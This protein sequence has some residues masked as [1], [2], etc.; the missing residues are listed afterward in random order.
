MEGGWAIERKVIT[1]LFCDVVGSTELAER[2]DPEDVD[3]MM[4]TYHALARRRIE[5]HG[6]SVE[7][8]I[9]DAVVGVFGAP[10]VREDDAAR[11]VRAALTII[12]DL[13]ASGLGLE[14]RIGIHTGEAV[15]RVG[16]DR[17][18]EEGF[19]TGD[20]LNTAARLQAIANPGEIVAGDP[21]YRMAAR[22][23]EWEDLGPVALK[24]KSLP[25]QVW[26]PVR[27]RVEAAPS[28][29]EATPFLGR[30]AE[31]SVLL[32]AFE[33]AVR[34]PKVEL[35][36]IVA[37]AGMGKSRLIRELGRR[38]LARGGVT[39]RKGR[40]LPYGDGI[41][42]W[43]LG[44][45]VK[46]EAGV[47]ETDDQQTL[48]TKLDSAIR[49]PDLAVHAWFR[50]RLAPLVGLRT[51]ALA[52]TQEEAFSAWTRFLVSLAADGP[53]VLVF[54]DVHWADPA[55][56]AF[57]LQLAD[58]TTP[59]PILLVVTARPELAD[60][61][62]AWLERASSGTVQLASLADDAIRA[63]VEGTLEGGS[64]TLI[65]T[66]L[67]RAAGS[68][69]YAEQLAALIRERG[70]SATD[71]T[72]DASAIPS[73]V[74]ALL[75]ARIDALP[76]ELKPAL[77][78]A[79]VIGR[80]FWSGAIDALEAQEPGVV[81]PN[82]DALARRE[83]TRSVDPSSMLGEAEYAFWH[84]LL[85]DVAYSFLPR[86]AR[87]AKHRTA[88]AWITQ[89]AGSGLA[90]LAE[91]VAD[92]LRRALDLA[93][94][95]GAEDEV[96]SI[97]SDLASALMAAADHTARMDP[98]RAI[99]QF[100]QALEL[101]GQADL[102]R[103]A[104]LVAL[105]RALSARV[106]P[107]DAAS[108]L[109]EA[110]EAYR[111]AGDELAAAETSVEFARVL[112]N[113][114]RGAQAEAVIDAIRP[115]LEAHPG[116]GLVDLYQDDAVNAAAHN[117]V[118]RVIEFASRSLTLAASL[119]LPTPYRALAL[120]GQTREHLGD[121]RGIDEFHE[122]TELAVSAGDT[123]FALVAMAN[124]AGTLDHA[125]KALEAFDE[126]TALAARFGLVDRTTRALRLDT[127]ALAGRWDEVIE[128][129]P[130]LL[131]DAAFGGDAYSTFMARMTLA[132]VKLGRG[133]V[134]DPL[135]DLMDAA[136][137]IGFARYVPAG[138]VAVIAV[139]RGEHER[140][141]QILVEAVGLVGDGERLSNL[142][143]N[144]DA[145]IR[146][147]DL[148]LAQQLLAK[149]GRELEPSEGHQ[150]NRLA[151]AT[152]LEAEGNAAGA[153]AKYQVSAAWF[154]EFGW[155]QMQARALAGLGRCRIKLGDS[156]GGVQ[157]LRQARDIASYLRSP[158]LLASIDR[159]I[160]Q[161]R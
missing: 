116:S 141:R 104:A 58:L 140:A 91:I 108:A 151:R 128:E 118:G 28:T 17:Q 135:D 21:T 102:R 119:G 89:R 3:R 31:L 99:D 7:K 13:E 150:G 138:L 101:L 45:I 49:E 156:A 92:H 133:E 29:D 41:S 35:V 33:D 67:E 40:S 68:P 9:G 75:A 121:P 44:E 18:P 154:S 106:R 147:G 131:A 98:E 129:S 158:P 160:S 78:D 64:P 30:D 57:L 124:R 25:V 100:R 143:D 87:L 71:E 137:A 74:Q 96:P 123:R 14:M 84:A 115:Y 56:V 157:A 19:A 70:I 126:A 80:V 43:A 149:G 1:A 8:F 142:N 42:F 6:G 63:L 139:E 12:G 144:I 110:V 39:W 52:A 159:A 51:D 65:E 69:L 117:D 94:T 107:A 95:L 53:F 79:S 54:E 82:L 23:F 4:R 86:A 148:G 113:A 15:V 36:T 134:N 61:H 81:A 20:I 55:M 2:L 130:A 38:V 136:A 10:T 88:A 161:G 62:P 34:A 145:A 120:R 153:A 155:L 26:R 37:E 46:T 77:L 72:L 90:D 132:D 59:V 27:P 111:A 22:E 66:V 114:G 109:E 93:S 83:L 48:A 50:D 105:S 103:P 60:R 122:A 5:S 127:L 73:T 47:L 76:R 125:G 97:G 16:E 112:R 152:L 24:G 146:L 85:R 32:Q 11:A